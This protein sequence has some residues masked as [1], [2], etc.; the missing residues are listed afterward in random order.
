MDRLSAVLIRTLVHAAIGAA[1]AG[2]CVALGVFRGGPAD[3]PFTIIAGV[4][5]VFAI[6]GLVHRSR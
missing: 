4:A 3:R 2:I 1:I 6:R 5:T